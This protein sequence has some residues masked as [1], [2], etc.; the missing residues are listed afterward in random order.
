M[1]AL[2]GCPTLGLAGL[3]EITMGPLKHPLQTARDQA[4]DAGMKVCACGALMTRRSTRC[5]RCTC[6]LAQ[7]RYKH[8]EK[9]KAALK[10][11]G[12]GPAYRAA[13]V[14]YRRG[15]TGQRTLAR[16]NARRIFVGEQY[17]GRA[18]TVERAAM[19]NS[20]IQEMRSA[21]I[22]GQQ[23]RAKAETTA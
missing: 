17:H 23:T 13:L 18:Q 22:K 3:Q 14:R 16:V 12:H 6:R 5:R 9:G 2:G 10:R 7:A 15:V 21:F 1:V 4:L 20:H 8:T 19:I 11:Y